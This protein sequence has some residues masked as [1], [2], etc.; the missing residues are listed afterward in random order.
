MEDLIQEVES[1]YN[2]Y[3][4]RMSFHNLTRVKR[5]VLKFF[6]KASERKISPNNLRNIF[7]DNL[8]LQQASS[9]YSM[10]ILY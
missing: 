8:T 6:Q 1:A 10:D 2:G 9:F 5:S 4:N 3:M 7:D